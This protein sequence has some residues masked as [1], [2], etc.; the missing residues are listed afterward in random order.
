MSPRVVKALLE[1]LVFVLRRLPLR[2]VQRL[3]R[4]LAHLTWPFLRRDKQRA[5]D[6][7]GIAFPEMSHVERRN[8][9]FRCFAHNAMTL[10]EVLHLMKGDCAS[11]A[12]VSRA[13]GWEN[14]EA[15]QASG[16]PLVMFTGHIGNWEILAAT[17]GCKIGLTTVARGRDEPALEQVIGGFRERFGTKTLN[18]GEGGTAKDLLRVLRQGQALGMLI[19]QDTRVQGV[20]VPFFGRSAFTPVG[21]TRLALRTNAIVIPC[22]DERLPD[23]SH[24]VRFHPAL[25]LPEDEVEATAL[26]TRAIEDHIRR[27]P[28]QWVWWHK[29]WRRQPDQFTADGVRR[30][31]V[32]EARSRPAAEPARRRPRPADTAGSSAPRTGTD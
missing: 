27:A 7:L 5:L 15:A 12:R 32:S 6:H 25:E 21:G 9:A 14:V 16:R 29:R 4:V 24:V 11:I 13:E 26:M 8:L 1:P 28:E 23:G 19:D 22:F 17:V 10:L 20:W 31:A 2:T 18:R 30:G 3:A